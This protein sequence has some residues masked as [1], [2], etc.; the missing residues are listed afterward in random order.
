[1]YFA[2]RW[3]IGFTLLSKDLY[4]DAIN[5][6]TSVEKKYSLIQK[7]IHS[8]NIDVIL[9]ETQIRYLIDSNILSENL[10]ISDYRRVKEVLEYFS[11]LD[12]YDTSMMM[13]ER[14]NDYYI[15]YK[16]A[17]YLKQL[18]FC[19]PKIIFTHHLLSAAKGGSSELNEI[20]NTTN[21]LPK[22][23]YLESNLQYEYITAEYAKEIN[24]YTMLHYLEG[25]N[26]PKFVANERPVFKDMLEGISNG[27]YLCWVVRS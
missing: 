26:I 13:Y 10:I 9:K 24:E 23:R 4:Y 16:S 12:R 17:V 11:S 14:L 3:N 18:W 2:N 1:M 15:F 8:V 19:K 7:A 6:N 20:L 25:E 5:N 22:M 21:F 27:K